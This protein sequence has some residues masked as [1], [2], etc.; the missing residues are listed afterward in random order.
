V[1]VATVDA[2]IVWSEYSRDGGSNL[3]HLTILCM[4]L[5]IVRSFIVL[6]P[7]A[8]EPVTLSDVKAYL[9]WEL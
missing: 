3:F 2:T 7:P 5:A 9:R 1:A 6:T 4:R 8:T